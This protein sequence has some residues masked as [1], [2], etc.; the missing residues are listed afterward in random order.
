[1]A[2]LLVSDT[3]VLVDLERGGI[4]ADLAAALTS[5]AEHPRCR[6]PKPDVRQRLERYRKLAEEDTRD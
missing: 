5:I 4:L 1:M 2:T 6:L 3:S